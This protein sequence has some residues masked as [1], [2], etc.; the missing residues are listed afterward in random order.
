MTQETGAIEAQDTAVAVAT[1]SICN[2][3]G[4]RF[5]RAPEVPESGQ[6]LGQAR[7]KPCAFGTQ[8]GCNNAQ[9]LARLQRVSSGSVDRP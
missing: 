8:R 4:A 9:R 2:A 5:P 6:A 7:P 3:Q 1:A